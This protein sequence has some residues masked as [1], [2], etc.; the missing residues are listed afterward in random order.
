M[1]K[2]GDLRRGM[3]DLRSELVGYR[4]NVVGFVVGRGVLVVREVVTGG[5]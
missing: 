2:L 4:D 5:R 1:G 3:E